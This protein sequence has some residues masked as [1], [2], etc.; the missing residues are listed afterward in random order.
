[1]CALA[2]RDGVMPVNAN[3]VTLDPDCEH[4]DLVRDAPRSGR[5]RAALSN[6]FGFGGSN[7]CVVFRHPDEAD[8]LV[9]GGR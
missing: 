6:S 9:A 4:L 1:V 2:I 3:L 8:A 7:S 5:I